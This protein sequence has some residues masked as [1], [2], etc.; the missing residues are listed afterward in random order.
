VARFVYAAFRFPSPSMKDC[1][2]E[3][4]I[5]LAYKPAAKPKLPQAGVATANNYL[6]RQAVEYYV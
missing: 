6:L 4:C 3:I 1:S 5:I 2:Y